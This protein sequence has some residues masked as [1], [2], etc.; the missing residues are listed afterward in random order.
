MLQL[1]SIYNVDVLY[2]EDENVYGLVLENKTATMFFFSQKPFPGLHDSCPKAC[3]AT[4]KTQNL[5]SVSI[6]LVFHFKKTRVQPLI[7]LLA[8]ISHQPPYYFVTCV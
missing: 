7:S 5:F 2:L 8:K 1:S 3:L 6:M 4:T